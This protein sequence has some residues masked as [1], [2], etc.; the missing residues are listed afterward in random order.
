MSSARIEDFLFD[1]E[2]EDEI[3]AHGLTVNRILQLLDSVYIKLS[4]RKHRR[5]I[6]LLVGRDKSGICISVPIEPTNITKLWRPITAWTSKRG[7]ET[8]LRKYERY[9]EK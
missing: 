6:Y 1:E 5:G 2:N 4:N 7:E 8:I 3:C 9:H